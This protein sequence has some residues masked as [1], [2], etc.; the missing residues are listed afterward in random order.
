MGICAVRDRLTLLLLRSGFLD[1]VRALEKQRGS[2]SDLRAAVRSWVTARRELISP[3]PAITADIVAAVQARAASLEAKQPGEA[4]SLPL[5]GLRLTESAQ[6]KGALAEQAVSRRRL[7]HDAQE[8]DPA[9]K[10]IFQSVDEEVERLLRHTRPRMGMC[11]KRWGLKAK[12]LR[13]GFGIEWKSPAKMNPGV[14][15]D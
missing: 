1:T 7:L 9:L 13:Q 15:F 14:L 12:L 11:H 10:S 8:D 4:T 2:S 5:R 3:T 6:P